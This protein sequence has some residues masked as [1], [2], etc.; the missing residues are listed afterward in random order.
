MDKIKT[1]AVLSSGGDAPG[2]NAGIRAVV[3]AAL[4]NGICVKGVLH[5]YEGLIHGEFKEMNKF[6]V[7]NIINIGGTILFTARSKEFMEDSGRKKAYDQLKK[8]EVDALVVLGGDGSFKGAYELSKLGMPVIG[9]PATI[10]LDIPCTEYTIGFDTA[11][12]T[13][14]ECIDKLR[15]TSSSHLRCSVIEVMGRNAGFIA[16]YSGISTGAEEILI[17]EDMD[18]A[19]LDS[20]ITRVKIGMKKGKTHYMIVI[21]EG[22]SKHLGGTVDIAK[23]IELATGIETRATVLGYVQRGGSPTCRDRVIASMMGVHAVKCL[24]E[25]RLNRVVILKDGVVKD[26]DIQEALSIKRSYSTEFFD[27]MDG[28]ESK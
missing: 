7:S 16:S 21:A 20:I 25:N 28:V 3:R 17:P 22:M 2:M 12:N 4:N 6:S 18:F 10:D 23:K 24:L 1:I 27:T 11:I 5:G 8:S 15:D 9:I 19:N 26:I 14:M 13:A